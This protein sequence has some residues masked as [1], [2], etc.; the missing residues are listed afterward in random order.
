M[1]AF[2]DFSTELTEEQKQFRQFIRYLHERSLLGNILEPLNILGFDGQ[3]ITDKDAF[4]ASYQAFFLKDEG[5]VYRYDLFQQQHTGLEFFG[6]VKGK[7]KKQKM[8]SLINDGRHAFFGAFCDIVVTEDADMLNKT[9]FLY[10]LYDIGTQVMTLDEFIAFQVKTEPQPDGFHAMLE[11]LRQFNELETIYEESNDDRV[12]VCKKIP[13][14]CWRV[15]DC[16]NFVKADTYAYHYFTK[17]V[18]N[19]STGTLHK[20]VTDVC[21]LALETFGRDLDGRNEFKPEELDNEQWAGRRWLI[22]ETV[23]QLSL[24]GKLCLTIFLSLPAPL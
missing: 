23:I 11:I 12:W 10:D 9:K 21:R 14:T 17:H 24:R 8:M 16:V 13:R 15:F 1:L 3:T 4:K 5:D 7:P 18:N 22:A 20:E 19:L 2:V 6:I